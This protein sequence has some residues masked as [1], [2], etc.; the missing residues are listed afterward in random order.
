[1]NRRHFLQSAAA[2]A[3]AVT[4][5]SSA[6]ERIRVAIIGLRGRGRSLAASFARV[7]DCEVSYLVDVDSNVLAKAVKGF[8]DEFGKRPKLVG[9]LRRVLEDKEIDA[10]GISAPDHWHAPAGI[11]ACDAGK[12]VYVEK[13][14]AHNIHEGELLVEAARRNK[15]IVQHGTQARS[16]PSTIR[17]MEYVQSGKLGRVLMAKAW[18]VQKRADIGHK[19][20]SPEPE[21][22]DYDTWLG[23]AEWM[24]FNQNRFHYTWHWNWNFGSGDMGNDGAHQVDQARWALGVELPTEVTGMGRKLFFDDDQQTPDTMVIAF[25]YPDKVLLFEMRIWNPYAMENVENGVAVYGSEGMLEIGRW[26]RK[27]GYRVFDGKGKLVLEDTD[28]LPDEHTKNFL[29]CMRSRQKPNAEIELGNVSAMHLHLGNIVARTGRPI[30]FDPAKRTILGDTE[31]SA[32]MRRQYRKH[33]ATPK[34]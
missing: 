17:A 28:N 16:R 26:D 24:P 6:N 4:P 31:A 13:P 23:P 19:P 5:G 34:G 20:D 2:G 33:W 14:C 7:P 10:V 18:N 22:V 11:L 27:L 15:R 21:G 3:A 8:E 12:D 25:N 9:D 29:D 32:L 30:R 1:M